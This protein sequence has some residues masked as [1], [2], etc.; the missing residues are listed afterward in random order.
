MSDERRETAGG[1]IQEYSRYIR[2]YSRSTCFSADPP[3]AAVPAFVWLR[4]LPVLPVP[5]S[6]PPSKTPFSMDS[7]TN[8]R[9]RLFNLILLQHATRLPDPIR[10]KCALFHSPDSQSSQILLLIA[11]R[12][13]GC[14]Q[15]LAQGSA[16][17]EYSKSLH[18]SRNGMKQEHDTSCF[19]FRVSRKHVSSAFTPVTGVAV[20]SSCSHRFATARQCTCHTSRHRWTSRKTMHAAG[21]IL[22]FSSES[23]SSLQ[24]HVHPVYFLSNTSR[25]LT[26]QWP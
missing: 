8:T 11:H 5:V 15:A 20:S 24:N 13:H 21:G 16:E 18:M 9:L 25:K 2:S 17:T 26:R 6:L 22:T 14:Y 1:G 3:A 23:G 12:K 10:N 7:N 4:C 19:C